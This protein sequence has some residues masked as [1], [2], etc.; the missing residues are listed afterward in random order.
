MTVPRALVAAFELQALSKT[1]EVNPVKWLL[2]EMMESLLKLDA[3]LQYRI[4]TEN[5]ATHLMMLL[6]KS[7]G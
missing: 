2:D 3:D 1:Y 7:F 5:V 4:L 6:S